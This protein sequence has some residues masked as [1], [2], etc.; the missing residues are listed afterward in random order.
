D[1]DPL[2][3]LADQD[4]RQ[5]RVRQLPLDVLADLD[6]LEDHLRVVL[7]ARVPVR[8]PV[9]DDA[10]APPA[11][12]DLLAP[13]VSGSSASPVGSVSSVFLRRLRFGF[14]SATGCAGASAS[15]TGCAWPSCSSRTCFSMRAL[16]I[17][18]EVGS[19]SALPGRMR[20][21]RRSS[22]SASSVVSVSV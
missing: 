12:V 4:V 19:L 18:S 1:R 9:V 15:S 5:A 20:R 14:S 13:Y 22:G 7:A 21:R 11:R 3:V 17:S 10:D 2:V 6:V 8:L 16:W